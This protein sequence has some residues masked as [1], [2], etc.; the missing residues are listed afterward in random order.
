MS[1]PNQIVPISPENLLIAETY[2]Q[3][4]SVLATANQLDL[5]PEQVTQYLQLPEVKQFINQVYFDA[6]YRN[7]FKLMEVMDS[8]VDQKLAEL[9]EAG[10]G[11]SK[12]ILE[13]LTA[14]HKMKLEE[15]KLLQQQQKDNLRTQVNVQI[16]NQN[17]FSGTNYGALL[18]RLMDAEDKS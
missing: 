11:S 13:I 8:L 5:H 3:T 15:Q 6:G 2:L 1:N 12:D 16:N 18:D 17:P 4:Q 9:S 10:I 14:L 7:R